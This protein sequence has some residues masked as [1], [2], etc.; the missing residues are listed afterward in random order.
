MGLIP[1]FLST[2]SEIERVFFICGVGVIF[3]DMR[4]LRLK[5]RESVRA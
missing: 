5:R 3:D 4:I 2:L 1:E